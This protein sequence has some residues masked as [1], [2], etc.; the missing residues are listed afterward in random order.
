[1]Q[2]GHYYS[3]VKSMEDEKWYCMDDDSVTLMDEADIVSSN[4]YMLF[5][6]LKE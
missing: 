5:Y 6:Q 3:Y 1:M 2:G 4:A